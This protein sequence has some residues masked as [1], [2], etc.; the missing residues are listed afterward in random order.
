MFIC[1]FGLVENKKQ[2]IT[3]QWE[4]ILRRSCVIDPRLRRAAFY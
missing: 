4:V 3:C 1:M 2:K